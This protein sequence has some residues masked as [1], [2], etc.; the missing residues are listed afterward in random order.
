MQKLAKALIDGIRQI[1]PSSVLLSGGVDS[2]IVACAVA[3]AGIDCGYVFFDTPFTTRRDRQAVASLSV[4]LNISVS[5]QVTNKDYWANVSANPPNRC[6]LCKDHLL[7]TIGGA[8]HPVLDGTNAD[9]L[10]RG[11]R[12]GLLANREHGVSSPLAQLGMTKNEVR[13][14]ALFWGLPNWDRPAQSCLATRFPE[15]WRHRHSLLRRIERLEDGLSEM[16]AV[17]RARYSGDGL[18]LEFDEK[19]APR[20]VDH[21]PALLRLAKT[22]GFDCPVKI[23]I[24]NQRYHDPERGVV[25][26]GPG[27]D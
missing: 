8:G 6:Y 5:L 4:F 15:G 26:L 10:A 25:A 21:L 22:C 27:K 20:T 23:G 1:N 16:F 19:D 2:S 13:Q 11:D 24:I 3:M 17:C 12:P 14:L 7:S 9:D 18:C